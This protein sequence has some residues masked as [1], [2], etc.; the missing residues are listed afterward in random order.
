MQFL[1]G[2]MNLIRAVANDDIHYAA[3]ILPAIGTGVR[4]DDNLLNCVQRKARRR[5]RRISTF[6]D[7]GKVG[8]RVCIGNAVYI[9]AVERA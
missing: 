9:E 3:G 1:H 7:G 8:G 5:C 2:A 6:I 4:A